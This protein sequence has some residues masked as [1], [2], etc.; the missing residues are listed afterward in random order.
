[1]FPV[2]LRF[3]WLGRDII[4]GT[5]GVLLIAGFAAGIFLSVNIAKRNGY[6]SSQVFDYSLLVSAGALAGAFFAGF[7][8][9]LPE[10]IAGGFFTYPPAFISW[11]GIC[12]GI[13]TLLILRHFWK[14]N[15]FNFLDLL[16]QD[17]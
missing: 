16:I 17:L 12:G 14:I 8:L 3:Q 1:M 10:R 9:F 2:L 13:I 7:I 11:G 15:F 4:I 6:S 5:Y